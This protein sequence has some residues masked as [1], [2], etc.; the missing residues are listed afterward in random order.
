MERG[1]KL[2]A[3]G[4]EGSNISDADLNA[5]FSQAFE[6]KNVLVQ[7]LTGG[8]YVKEQ[9]NRFNGFVALAGL[10]YNAGPGRAASEIEKWGG[11]PRTLA[12]QYHKQIGP[13]PDQVTVQPGIVQTDPATGAKWTRFPVFANQNGREIFQ[14]LYLRRVPGRNWGLLNFIFNPSLMNAVGLYENDL[15]PG[16]DSPNRALVAIGAELRF[17]QETTANN[18]FITTPLSQRDPAWANIPLGFADAGQTLGSHGCTV[19]VLT[20]MANGFGFQETPATLNEKLKAVGPNQGFFGPLV[21]WYGVPRALPGIKLNKLVD[22]REVP[23]PMAEIDA[24]LDAGKPIVAEL[25]MSPNPGLQKHW[26][27]IYARKDG[28][29]LIHDPWPV[30]A[31]PSASLKQRYGFA[32]APAQI[33]TFCVYFDNPNFNPRPNPPANETL[34]VVVANVP[35]VIAAGGLALRDQPNAVGSTIKMRLPAGTVLNLLEPAA[36]ARP[37]IGVWGQWLNVRTADNQTGWVAAWYVFGQT[38]DAI[39]KGLEVPVQAPLGTKRTVKV[40]KSYRVVYVRAAGTTNSKII[41][42]VFA[43]SRLQ[44]LEPEADV[45]AKVG[46]RGA[47]LKVTTEKGEIGFISAQFLELE[48]LP[49]PS[50]AKTAETSKGGTEAMSMMALN[51]PDAQPAL[52]VIAD[53]GLN[54]RD[55]PS[56]TANRIRVLPFGT[57]ILLREPLD[58]ALPKLGKAGTWVAVH[59]L[60]GITG[61]VSGEWVQL[62]SAPP[63]SPTQP[64]PAVRAQGVAL[65]VVDTRLFMGQGENTGSEWRVTAGTPLR[66]INPNADW[67]KIGNNAAWVQ[68]ESYAFKRG[69]VRGSAL[70]APDAPDRRRRVL[71]GPLPFGICAWNYGLH[72]EFDKGLFAGSGKTGWVLMT[73]RVQNGEGR[74]YNPWARAGYGVI[75]RLNN[76]YGGSGTIPTPDKYD[77]FAAQCRSWAANSRGCLI[78][79][80]GNEMNNPR[81]WPNQDPW[82]P[83]NNLNDDITPEKYAACFNRV[84][85]AIKSVQPNAIV[86]PG[87]VDPF[88]G[89]RMSNL[90]Y[91]ERM[92]AAITDLDAIALHCYTHGYTPDLVTSMQRFENDPLRWQY[93]HF[94]AYSTLMDVIP[95]RHRNKPIYITE[96]DPHGSTP[97]AGGQNGWVQAAYAEIDRYNLQARAQ[98]IQCL[99]LYRWSR[100]DIYSIVDRPAVQADIRATIN[101]TDYRWRA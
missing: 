48:P 62:A 33:I 47:W 2:A 80:I 71:D 38:V 30:P 26:V 23:A 96:T 44:A 16:E 19:T 50:G 101:G 40:S 35:D 95:P 57:I 67:D 20:M 69:F 43:G 53:V 98:Q 39:D 82:N 3:L 87:A 77:E 36:S 22:C 89:P 91:F 55:A 78:Y 99:I 76:D 27:L 68:V 85:A 11:D 97:W 52:R 14:Y 6:T 92:L 72:D 94:R 84:R 42:S 59:T 45:L 56:M 58:V 66:V 41:T 46:K 8:Q 60:D 9:I 79:V 93:Y 49:T 15:P 18:M 61:F 21:A 29:Y 74:D 73:H 65:A 5:R 31:E 17:S 64:D 4:I 25:D 7:V 10:A 12:L 90:E 100:D 75:A 81:E 88:Q 24:L 28:D 32:G 54:L 13:G 83:G 70:R 37:K 86:V 34:V 1:I 51:E 63:I